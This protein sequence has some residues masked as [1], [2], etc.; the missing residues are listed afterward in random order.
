MRLQSSY[1]FVDHLS[2]TDRRPW[3]R[4]DNN[5]KTWNSLSKGGPAAAVM[6]A[7]VLVLATGCVG[8]RVTYAQRP[9]PVTVQA[10]EP[11]PPPLVAMPPPP[12]VVL[13]PAPPQAP[14]V[15]MRSAAEL[16]GML[17]PV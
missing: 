1:E 7:G 9:Y 12:A 11:P 6:L 15:P 2:E 16:D 13:P 5:M 10:P 8:D 17:A 3:R 4:T 14:V